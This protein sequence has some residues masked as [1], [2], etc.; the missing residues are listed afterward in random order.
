MQNTTNNIQN[1]NPEMYASLK[2]TFSETINKW[3]SYTD[4]EKF[5]SK[6]EKKQIIEYFKAAEFIAW[7]L[8]KEKKIDDKYLYDLHL[9]EWYSY[10]EYNINFL[11]SPI[12]STTFDI[13]LDS[14][15]K[16]VFPWD[17]YVTQKKQKEIEAIRDELKKLLGKQ[18]NDIK[19]PNLIVR[20]DMVYDQ[21]KREILK[22]SEC[23]PKS[24]I[25]NYSTIPY[26]ETPS[27]LH[28]ACPQISEWL[29]FVFKKDVKQIE[30]FQAIC[31]IIILSNKN[32]NLQ[33]FVEIKGPGR[34]GKSLAGKLMQSLIA[35][36]LRAATNLKKLHTSKHETANLR[37]KNLVIMPDQ[38]AWVG[39]A[40]VLKAL[41][42]GDPINYEL[43]YK[44]PGSFYFMGVI[45]ILTNSKLSYSSTE[46][47]I[48]RRRIVFNFGQQVKAD[49]ADENLL[50][51]IDDKTITGK[52]AAELPGFVNWVLSLS[53]QDA[54][55]A[56]K[57]HLKKSSQNIVDSPFIWWMRNYL[58]P[59]KYAKLGI[60]HNG[61]GP[62][63]HDVYS[64]YMLSEGMTPVKA[65]AF[66]SSLE[67]DW[68]TAFPDQ[69]LTFES[70]P[71]KGKTY[72]GLTY[73]NA[74]LPKLMPKDQA[75]LLYEWRKAWQ[76]HIDQ[77]FFGNNIN[78]KP[79][80]LLIERQS[81]IDP[82]TKK[83]IK[84]DHTIYDNKNLTKHLGSLPIIN[85][86]DAIGFPL[87]Y[88]K[89]KIDHINTIEAK[90]L[91]ENDLIEKL[92]TLYKYNTTKSETTEQ[93]FQDFLQIVLE[94]KVL[95]NITKNKISNEII[96]YWER[97]YPDK[98]IKK[99][100]NLTRKKLA[101]IQGLERI[102]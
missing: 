97:K 74:S 19:N 102:V 47:A 100:S 24:Y 33:F 66:A 27:E 78:L 72:V 18:I 16:S 6:S 65:Q 60:K 101:G 71:N 40:E 4:K 5:M 48:L 89:S 68:G 26:L 53:T 45:I 90:T 81:K 13:G 39:E 73:Q 38:E 46:S 63:L 82:L 11:W 93:F 12:S 28:K 30:L 9:N 3:N 70:I 29:N 31:Q 35:P 44:N 80:D 59:Y 15:L 94:T 23:G 98:P 43:K 61:F 92:L 7:Y 17:I 69:E 85:P 64:D 55:T 75:N 42:G 2:D 56:I 83:P 91:T 20:K 36:H 77:E 51:I 67:K 37:N 57:N 8:I 10:A 76:T 79:E 87:E 34:S 62:P 32:Y 88:K 86:K 21:Q 99:V 22:S 52:W 50:N 14:F 96:T 95:T 1:F 54:T 41:T 58:M 49:K 25:F 84:T